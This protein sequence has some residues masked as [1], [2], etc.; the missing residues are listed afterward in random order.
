M[1]RRPSLSKRV[2]WRMEYAGYRLVER[3]LSLFTLAQVDRLGSAIGSAFFYCSSKYRRLAIRN[4]R[5]AMGREK[6]RGE[7]D[8]LARATC[9]R[10]IANFLGTLKTT[11]LPTEEIEQHVSLLGE[12]H[13]RDALSGGKGAILVLGHMGNWELLN[14]LH[15]Y[16]PKGTPAGGIYQPL[17]NPL[18][19]DLLLR[20]REQDG[21]QLFNKRDGFHAPASFVQSGGLLIVVADQKVGRGGTPVP[22]FNRL[23]S[24]SPLPALLARKA[25]APVVAAG[26]ESTSPGKWQIV[27]EPLGPRPLTTDIISTL[28]KLIRRSPADFLWLHNRWRLVGKTPL[29]ISSRKSKTTPP[30]TNPMR[31]VLLTT[32][33]PDLPALERYLAHRDPSD[34]PLSCEFLFVT[35]QAE[36]SNASNF[37]IHNLVA[38][39]AG[40]VAAELTTLDENGVT[41]IELVLVLTPSSMLE[42][43]SK[44]AKVPRMITNRKE[45]P[46][47]EFLQSLTADFTKT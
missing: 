8:K 34:F 3:L 33:A 46:L 2:S 37:P 21:S 20:R 4:L 6:S 38:P 26:I 28:E 22:F 44:Q 7:I 39:S 16:L 47:D 42:E 10:T 9:Q 36:E 29:S 30:T 32:E 24:L 17:K 43:G 45:L 1:K 11:V 41:P 18:V 14:R 5:I 19:N 27:F 13:L 35:E 23:S 25:G 15:Q 40:Q 31:T 12:E